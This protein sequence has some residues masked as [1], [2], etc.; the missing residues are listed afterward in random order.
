M[1]RNAL[2]SILGEDQV[3]EIERQ[4]DAGKLSLADLNSLADKGKDI[5]TGVLTLI[6]GYSQPARSCVG[7]PAQRPLRRGNQEEGRREGSAS[8]ATSQLRH[9]TSGRR[10]SAELAGQAGAACLL[11]DLFAALKKQVP[12]SL[13]SVAVATSTGG[14]DACVRLARTWRNSRDVRDSYVAVANKIE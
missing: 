5:S 6:F 7:F 2:K 11:T 4:V 9:R 14:I 1:A 10:S 13:S 3:A 12:S 8:P